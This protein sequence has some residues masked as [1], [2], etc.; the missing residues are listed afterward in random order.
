MDK[1]LYIISVGNREI[2]LVAGYREGVLFIQ[3]LAT[4]K[5]SS[6][7][8]L[9][10]VRKEMAIYKSRGFLVSVNEPLPRLSTGFNNSN[11]ADMDS[12][13]KPRLVVAITAY[14]QLTQRRAIKFA[15]KV[16]AITI[17]SNVYEKEVSDKGVI[18]YRI[19]WDSINE[20]SLALLVAIYN[21]MFHVSTEAT[22]LK[23]VFHELNKKRGVNY[24]RF[25]AGDTL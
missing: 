20:E 15:D 4:I 21:A 18:S 19:D 24:H 23:S 13:G 7:S 5:T 25:K 8:A 22:Y 17:P 6:R 3:S 16:R 11:L 10:S 9:A 1:K 2:C 12:S 14:Q